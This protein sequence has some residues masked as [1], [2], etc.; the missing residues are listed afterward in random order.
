MC[1][2]E[3]AH[4]KTLFHKFIQRFVN[5]GLSNPWKPAINRV[6]E[7]QKMTICNSKQANL[8]AT[9]FKEQSFKT[10]GESSNDKASPETT[11]CV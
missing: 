1:K 9:R 2:F 6:F 3:K 10:T 4:S 8:V 5:R 7:N 11:R